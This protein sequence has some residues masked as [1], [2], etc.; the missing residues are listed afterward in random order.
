LFKFRLGL[1]KFILP[2]FSKDDVSWERTNELSSLGLTV[3]PPPNKRR[4]IAE[5]M[6]LRLKAQSKLRSKD[7]EER[8]TNGQEAALKSSVAYVVIL[9]L[10]HLQSKLQT[11][12]TN[13]HKD[14]GDIIEHY[15]L[16]QQRANVLSQSIRMAH[17]NSPYDYLLYAIDFQG[18][19]TAGKDDDGDTKQVH[20]ALIQSGFNII[21]V[22]EGEIDEIGKRLIVSSDRK[23]KDTEKQQQS[24]LK[25]LNEH[26]VIVQMSLNSFLL[27]SMDDLFNFLLKGDDTD[28]VIGVV[29]IQ[30][31][32][33]GEGK[34]DEET[35]STQVASFAL[36]SFD[37]SAI[38]SELFI[39]K[40]NSQKA[41][42]SYLKSLECTYLQSKGEEAKFHPKPIPSMM[43]AQKNQQNNPN[44]KQDALNNANCRVQP[45]HDS[46]LLDRCLYD[47]GNVG[48]GHNDCTIVSMKDDARVAH[49]HEGSSAT[50]TTNDADAGGT[51]STGRLG[52]EE[53][54]DTPQKENDSQESHDSYCGKPW[55]YSN[56]QDCSKDNSGQ[57]ENICTWLCSEWF[58]FVNSN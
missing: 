5:N 15:R 52:A 23:L 40:S 25:L 13:E 50:T 42:S 39:F 53:P 12:N 33:M 30:K 2:T 38:E 36:E 8:E 46:L 37:T 21:N 6:Y 29:D 43:V 24:Q 9:H 49:F 34:A 19:S 20:E 32:G 17:T 51:G 31:G 28:N 45:E 41:I 48:I 7:S 14:E 56:K 10:P 26:D 58:H 54:D 55:E 47:V 44:S 57:Q 4:K 3:P 35:K 16:L 1:F 27:K 22:K 18:A 11:S